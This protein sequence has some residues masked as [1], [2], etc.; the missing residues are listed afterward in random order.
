MTVFDASGHGS[1]DSA[2]RFGR[3]V[4]LPQRALYRNGEPVALGGR[5]LDLLS[6]I[7]LA[8]G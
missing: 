1:R 4:L 8:R 2:V 7:V 6:S 5:A 3:F